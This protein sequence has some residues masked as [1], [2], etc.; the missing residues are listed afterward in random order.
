[1]RGS[2]LELGLEDVDDVVD[3]VFLEVGVLDEH[4]A[5]SVEHVLG[6]E[7][8]DVLQGLDSSI[9]SLNSSR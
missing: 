1:M 6:G 4:F 2:V 5:W 8:A 3:G 9:S 7:A